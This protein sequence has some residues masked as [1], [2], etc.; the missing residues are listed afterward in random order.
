MRS[1]FLTGPEPDDSGTRCAV[2]ALHLDDALPAIRESLRRLM[3]AHL[4]HPAELWNN[5]PVARERG[6]VNRG[7]GGRVSSTIRTICGRDRAG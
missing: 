7:N 5:G 1:V 3:A 2:V 6:F 4:L